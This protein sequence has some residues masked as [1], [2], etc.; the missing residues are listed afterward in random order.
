M[1]ISAGAMVTVKQT[2]AM[3][4]VVSGRAVPENM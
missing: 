4:W 1:T 3:L 2:G